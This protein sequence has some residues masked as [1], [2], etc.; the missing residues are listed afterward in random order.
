MIRRAGRIEF[1]V[2]LCGFASQPHRTRPIANPTNH[3]FLDEVLLEIFYGSLSSTKKL[4]ANNMGEGSIM[5]HTFKE[6]NEIL[7]KSLAPSGI[8]MGIKVKNIITMTV[9][10]I[11]VES[12][13]IGE[14]GDNPQMT[15]EMPSQNK[16][17][18][19][20]SLERCTEVRKA[21]LDQRTESC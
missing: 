14:I 7:D 21:P 19:D 17:T 16:E 20:A 13:A 12:K 10:A 6:A 2:G 8:I 11:V 4:I 9:R 1:F 3:K 15:L 18:R 5:A